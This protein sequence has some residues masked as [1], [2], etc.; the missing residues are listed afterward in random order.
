EGLGRMLEPEVIVENVAQAFREKPRDKKVLITLGPTKSPI[1]PVRFFTN[2]SS[3]KM[4][5]AMAWTAYRKGYDVCVIQGNCEV[6]LPSAVEVHRAESA[7]KM[8]E[9]ALEQWKSS[10]Y[11]ISAAAV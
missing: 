9:I 8:R 2:R 5:A 4:G 11:F 6:P 1:D 10:D 3:G 7:K